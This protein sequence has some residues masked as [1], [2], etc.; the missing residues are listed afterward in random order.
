MVS[1]EGIAE[2]GIA[3][4]VVFQKRRRRFGGLA[5]LGGIAVVVVPVEIGAF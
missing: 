2:E 5:V 1:E 3:E 4:L